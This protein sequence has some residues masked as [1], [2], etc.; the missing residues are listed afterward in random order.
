MSYRQVLYTCHEI[1]LD[2]QGN[3]IDSYE[4]KLPHHDIIAKKMADSWNS[5]NI[6]KYF[7]GILKDK[8]ASAKMKVRKIK[9]DTVAVVTVLGKPNVRFSRNMTEEIFDQID[10]QFCDGW[11]EGFF[12]C[13]NVMKADDGT[14]FCVD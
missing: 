6:E 13:V 10:A 11:G 2:K 12:G 1:V 9:D 14:L 8:I 4:S 3:Y 5:M 7:D